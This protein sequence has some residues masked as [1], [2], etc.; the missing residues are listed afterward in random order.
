[1]ILFVTAEHCPRVLAA[2]QTL[3]DIATQSW[4]RNP[5]GMTRWPKKPSEKAMKARKSKLFDFLGRNGTNQISYSKRPKLS[6]IEDRKD[7]NHIS[8]TRKEPINW[9]TPRSILLPFVVILTIS[10]TVESRKSFWGEKDLNVLVLAANNSDKSKYSFHHQI[11]NPHS[12]ISNL[13]G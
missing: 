1:M 5:N 6:M 9:S 13:C 12:S 4:R 11:T 8:S 2:A 3:C 7:L 10:D